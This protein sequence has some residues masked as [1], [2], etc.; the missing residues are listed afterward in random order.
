LFSLSAFAFLVD[1]VG[2]CY[3][4]CLHFHFLE[5]LRLGV[6][7][8]CRCEFKRANDEGEGA[9][10]LGF[11]RIA[12][13]KQDAAVR[14]P[15]GISIGDGQGFPVQRAHHETLAVD[16]LDFAVFVCDALPVDG[17]FAID[18]RPDAEALSPT[19]SEIEIAAQHLDFERG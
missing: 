3:G 11:L 17:E 5:S 1:D 9:E 14:F 12:V 13:S 8:Q 15:S 6:G 18:R 19:A 4:P 2:R 10:Y 7:D 16:S